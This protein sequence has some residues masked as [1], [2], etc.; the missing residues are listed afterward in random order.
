[1]TNFGIAFT[2][3]DEE[4]PL[5]AIGELKLGDDRE[6]FQSVLGFWGVDDY[7]QSWTEALQRLLAGASTSCLATS[8]VDP[9]NANFVEVWP[10]YREQDEV[11][12]QNKLLF[13]DQL[14]HEFDPAAPWDSVDPRSLVNEDGRR[15]SEWRVSL[16]DIREFLELKPPASRG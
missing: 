15:I 4:D 2:G 9:S 13:L 1:M 16:D 12:V 3:F 14:P 11:Y 6:Y 7:L 10:L 8:I 5:V